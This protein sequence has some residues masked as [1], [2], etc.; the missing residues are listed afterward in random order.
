MFFP[1]DSSGRVIDP[2][3]DGLPRPCPP[4]KVPALVCRS[5]LPRLWKRGS[6]SSPRI[7]GFRAVA[8]S[9]C[10]AVHVAPQLCVGSYDFGHDGS[11][12]G[13]CGCGFL[14]RKA[15]ESRAGPLLPFLSLLVLLATAY[16]LMAAVVLPSG[17]LGRCVALFAPTP[18]G[19][20]T[21]GSS[22]ALPS[23]A[24]PPR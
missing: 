20:V 21:G 5:W 11:V 16:K 19:E 10:I 3:E 18:Q 22:L 15:G 17:N 4:L 14:W 1:E 6:L 23:L 13:R 12:G 24:R 8:T 9:W 2:E 7:L